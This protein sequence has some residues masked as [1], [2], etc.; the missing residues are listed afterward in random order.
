MQK[1]VYIPKMEQKANLVYKV[2]GDILR[3]YISV[4]S[5]IRCEKKK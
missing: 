4:N 1:F 3:A 5:Y 2:L